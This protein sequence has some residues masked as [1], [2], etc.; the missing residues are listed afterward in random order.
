MRPRRGARACRGWQRRRRRRQRPASSA[1]GR[2]RAP[3]TGLGRRQTVRAAAPTK[4]REG[5]QQEALAHAGGAHNK[6]R[7]PA[8]D[9]EGEVGV[10]GAAAD[11]ARQAADGELGKG[12]IGWR[13]GHPP[14]LGSVHTRGWDAAKRGSGSRVRS[15]GWGERC[16]VP[17]LSSS[18]CT[19]HDVS[20]LAHRQKLDLLSPRRAQ[21]GGRSSPPGALEPP[22]LRQSTNCRSER[23]SQP[24]NPILVFSS[25]AQP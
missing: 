20:C 9:G 12:R 22:A 17:P 8:G 19:G 7:L 24:S 11:G 2:A 16:S 25:A 23:L 3:A 6:Q 4:V 18:A 14:P 13:A 10:D 15:G 5:A 1:S 21:H